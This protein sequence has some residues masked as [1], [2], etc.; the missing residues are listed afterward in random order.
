MSQTTV[1]DDAKVIPLRPGAAPEAEPVPE[2]APAP[3]PAPAEGSRRPIIPA[4]LQRHNL[5]GT[6]SYAGGLGWH[7]ARY[8]GLRYPGV[9]AG[10]PVACGSRSGRTRPAPWSCWWH[11][12]EGARFSCHM[13]VA[14]G[15]AGHHDAMAAHAEGRKTR[16][17]RGQIIAPCVAGRWPWSLRG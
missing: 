12:T 5:R 14:A 7:R 13:A 15:R 11:W 1:H 10:V 2:P 6:V 3:A 17:A 16:K 4:P 8:H 9:P